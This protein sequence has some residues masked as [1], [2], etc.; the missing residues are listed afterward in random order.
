MQVHACIVCVT[1][2]GLVPRLWTDY[3][4]LTV[5]GILSNAG[6]SGN[7]KVSDFGLAKLGPVNGE[8]HITTHVIGTYG[9]AVSEYMATCHLYVRVWSGMA[10]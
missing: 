8:S 3:L 4:S 5:G 6:I 7:A 1:T 9:Y 10:E 2:F